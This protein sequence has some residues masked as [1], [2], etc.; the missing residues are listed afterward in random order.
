MSHTSLKL[1]TGFL[2]LGYSAFALANET[3]TDLV[4]AKL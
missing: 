4:E 2:F 1:I 3:D